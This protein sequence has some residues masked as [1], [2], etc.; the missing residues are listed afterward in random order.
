M[1]KPILP[2]HYFSNLNQDTETR[3][4]LK[5][6]CKRH[7]DPY[8]LYVYYHN[9]PTLLTYN[10]R[11]QQFYLF[12]INTNKLITCQPVPAGIDLASIMTNFSYADIV[13]SLMLMGSSHRLILLFHVTD[14]E[15]QIYPFNYNEHY[16]HYTFMGIT[17]LINDQAKLTNTIKQHF[18]QEG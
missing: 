14:T 1:N 6:E 11:E 4:N 5:L 8:S 16:S 15:G 7:Q 2:K 18:Q 3:V 10:P 17:H 13:P 9:Q 12:D